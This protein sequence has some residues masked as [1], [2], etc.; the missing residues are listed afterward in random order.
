VVAVLA[1]IGDEVRQAQ[2]IRRVA[3]WWS[4]TELW[5][6][7]DMEATLR[8]ALRHRRARS[9]SRASGGG[10]RRPAATSRAG[11]VERRLLRLLLHRPQ[12][13]ESAAAAGVAERLGDALCRQ[14][15]AVLLQMGPGATID[16]LMAALEPAECSLVADLCCT[17]P[18]E[19]DDLERLLAEVS[20][21]QLE[22][23]S[24]VLAQQ[25]ARARDGDIET[26]LE[27]ARQI[28]NLR[29]QLEA[30]RHRLLQPRTGGKR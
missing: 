9:G 26:K 19:G 2:T 4:G 1:D 3:E 18:E 23:Q 28:T 22:E 20:V 15:A 29:Q 16:Q 21:I 25:L 14:V 8:Q 27:L 13:R 7:A 17:E 30:E 6:Q 24:E 11:Q 12:G 5:L 10:G